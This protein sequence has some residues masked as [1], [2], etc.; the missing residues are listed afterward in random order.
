MSTDYYYDL[1][2][3]SKVRLDRTPEIDSI[4][5]NTVSL[6]QTQVYDG[7]CKVFCH[8]I[9]V[10]LKKAGINCRTINTLSLRSHYEHV[11]LVAFFKTTSIQYVLVDPTFSQFKHESN[12]KLIAFDEWPDEILK[13]TEEGSLM[14]E[15]LLERGYCLVDNKTFNLYLK[16]F[17]NLNQQINLEQLLISEYDVESSKTK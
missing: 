4:I 5:K 15:A 11:F 1:L 16:I 3:I 14:L 10:D 8:N 13:R 9:A 7:L 6:M 17:V 12:R 2:N